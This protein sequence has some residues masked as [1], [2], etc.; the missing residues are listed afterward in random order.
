MADCC[1]HFFSCSRS[2]SVRWLHD[3]PGH[4]SV[5]LPQQRPLDRPRRLYVSRACGIPLPCRGFRTMAAVSDRK[6]SLDSTQCGLTIR[7][8]RHRFAASA[9]P[10][11]IVALPPPQIGAGLTQA[12]GRASQT[13][14]TRATPRGNFAMFRAASLALHSSTRLRIAS[15]G[16]ARCSSGVAG[17][18]SR[19]VPWFQAVRP[20]AHAATT[21]AARACVRV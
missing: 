13:S 17:A 12:L 7:S 16:R 20:Q 3:W 8:S 18:D 6:R 5:L 1:A 9:K 15:R 19:F 4:Q 21:P 10:R 2:L 14:G 11:K